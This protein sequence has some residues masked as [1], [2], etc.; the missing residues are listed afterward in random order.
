MDEQIDEILSRIPDEVWKDTIYIVPPPISYSAT[1]VL[2]G[3]F[4]KCGYFP[5]IIR[6]K[7]KK[8]SSP[9]EYVIAEIIE[10]QSFK[11]RMRAKRENQKI[12]TKYIGEN[13]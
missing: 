5:N 7:K 12:V 11:D 6:I 3:I 2:V 4:S 13:K 1:L 8:R 9:P 10:T